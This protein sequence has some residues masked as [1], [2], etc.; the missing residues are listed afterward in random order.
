MHEDV[1][2]QGAGVNVGRRA[3]RRLGVD[4][5]EVRRIL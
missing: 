5:G 3:R 2:H 1:R 4:A